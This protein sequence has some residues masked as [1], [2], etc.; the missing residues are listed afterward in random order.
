MQLFL[1]RVFFCT[2]IW[3]QD[4]HSNTT[5]LHGLKYSYCSERGISCSSNATNNL[6]SKKQKVCSLCYRHAET[7]RRKGRKRYDLFYGGERDKPTWSGEIW[8][9]Q[10]TKFEVENSS[11]LL[12][13]D[14]W[15]SISSFC[16]LSELTCAQLVDFSSTRLLKPTRSYFGV[17]VTSCKWQAKHLTF[18]WFPNFMASHPTAQCQNSWNRWSWC[19]KYVVLTTL[20]VFYHSGWEAGLCPYT[21]G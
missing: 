1:K 10:K 17:R 11:I 4:F 2:Q 6:T 19:A 13:S 8:W 7:R 18:G 5:N 15:T 12:M 16:K 21:D 14:W 3:Y 20:N 9:N